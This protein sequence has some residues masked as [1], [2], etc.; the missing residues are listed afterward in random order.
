[1]KAQVEARIKKHGEDLKEFFNLPKDTDPIALCKQLRRLEVKASRI[2]TDVCNGEGP[3]FNDEVAED[4]ILEKILL[5]TW[6]LLGGF[7]GESKDMLFINRDPRGYALKIQSESSP[8]GM[9]RDWGGYGII[10]PDLSEVQ[11]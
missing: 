8:Q 9:F 3:Y 7:K 11:S 6:R 5:A 4:A 1:M 2:T 10:A